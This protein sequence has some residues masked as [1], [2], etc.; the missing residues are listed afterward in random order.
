MIWHTSNKID[1]LFDLHNLESTSLQSQASWTGAIIKLPDK[2]DRQVELLL[3]RLTHRD[4]KNPPA[5]L[6]LVSPI[7]QQQLDDGSLVVPSN[8]ELTFSIIGESGVQKWSEIVTARPDED[9]LFRYKGDG[10]VPFIFSIDK[11]RK[12]RTD[13]WLDDDFE[14]GLQLVCEST[15]MF[16][17]AIDGVILRTQVIGDVQEEKT[18]LHSPQAAHLF[19]QIYEGTVQLKGIYIPRGVPIT[20]KWKVT[21]EKEWKLWSSNSIGQ[22]EVNGEKNI[23]EY[24]LS[25]LYEI[26]AQPNLDFEIEAG[27]F[28]N[29]KVTSIPDMESKYISMNTEWRKR[30]KWLLSVTRDFQ[31]G[32]REHHGWEHLTP[33][34][35]SK[36][37]QFDLEDQQLL[38]RILSRYYWPTKF[39]PYVR[40][41][42]YDL[43]KA[44]YRNNRVNWDT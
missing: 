41:V 4:I 26:F 39:I 5:E 11:F 14:S 25:V 9:G 31:G 42:F 15:S 3:N 1:R 29:L 30:V 18:A 43:H 36:I 10:S 7:P 22:E 23:A 28:G 20:V 40:A 13:I 17:P 8:T 37:K 34:I 32:K 21:K 12:G 27:E 2:Y 19:R 38:Q 33:S 6:V 35:K 16:K 44:S 24:L